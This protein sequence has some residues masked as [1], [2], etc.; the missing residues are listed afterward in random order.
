MKDELPGEIAEN[1]EKFTGRDWLLEHLLEWLTTSNERLFLLVG[2]PGT[3][4][5]MVMAWLAGAGPAP[6]ATS[7]FDVRTGAQLALFRSQVGSAHFCQA[8]G[9]NIEPKLF[10]ENLA[11]QLAGKVSGYG[12]ALAA[13]LS[14]RVEI[15]N[16][17]VVRGDLAAGASVTGVS[18]ANLKLVDLGEEVS[19]NRALREPLK[20]LY[21]NGFDETLILLVDGL[22]VAA[23]YTGAMPT[24]S[25]GTCSRTSRSAPIE[26]WRRS[27]RAEQ[28]AHSGAMLRELLT[29]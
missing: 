19:F 7:P 11:R 14:D 20:R 29:D 5:S 27:P 23:T 26:H 9:G 17:T 21:A 10:A 25:S 18:I 1:V 15:T 8:N 12:I 28:L 16:S 13:S 3:G 6:R 22:D 24:W 4:K 2:G